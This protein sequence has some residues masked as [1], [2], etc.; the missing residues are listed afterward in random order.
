MRRGLAIVGITIISLVSW[1]GLLRAQAA[2]PKPPAAPQGFE[3]AS[4]KRSNPNP[5][6]PL[7]GAPMILPALG[8][9]TAQNVTL[10]LLVVG[11]YQK[12]PFEVVGGPP[13]QTSDKFDIQAKAQDGSVSTDGMLQMLQVLLADRFKLKVHTETREVPIYNLIVARS[14]GKLG[15]SLKPSTDT[16]PDYKETQQKMLEALARGGPTA[17]QS[18]MGKPGENR[19]C[20]ITQVPPSAANAGAITIQAKGQSLD[21]MVLLLKQFTGRP[22]VNKTGL[23]GPYDYEL[24]ID[25]QTILGL[26]QQLGLNVPVPA[27]LPE[28]P[29]LMTSLQ[30][31]LGLKLDS[32]RGQG[33]VLVI[34]SAELPT[35]D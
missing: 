25:L 30:E 20:S 13:W 35:A 34:D 17:L 1:N 14:D 26:Y 32:S 24:T 16:C 11:A 5:A 28:G 23:T 27:N 33:E 22:I 19:P 8:R 18:L 2:D 7:A 21:L 29:S 12:Q 6:T 10:R 15:A 3:V 31:N 9:L 4:V